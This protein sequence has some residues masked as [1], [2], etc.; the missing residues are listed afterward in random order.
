MSQKKETGQFRIIHD[1]S[2]PRCYSVNSFIPDE[3]ASV[4]YK[5]FDDVVRLVIFH[6]P[7][8]L[9]AKCDVADAFRIIPVHPDDNHLL[10][11]KLLEKYYFLIGCY[12]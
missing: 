9:I 12:Q 4:K 5:T 7:K 10:G 6:G 1:L 8:A 3:F 11:F 2:Q